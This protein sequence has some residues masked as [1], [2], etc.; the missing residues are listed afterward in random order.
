MRGTPNRNPRKTS[1]RRNTVVEH[2]PVFLSQGTLKKHIAVRARGIKQLADYLQ[3]RAHDGIVIAHEFIAVVGADIIQR[4]LVIDR[5]GR[6]FLVE[7]IRTVRLSADTPRQAVEVTLDVTGLRV[8]WNAAYRK[9]EFHTF[10]FEALRRL[11]QHVKP[12]VA[13]AVAA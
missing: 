6:L 12:H 13:K 9:H 10:A 3:D 7:P 2:H 4:E 11:A 1:H 5:Q 8:V